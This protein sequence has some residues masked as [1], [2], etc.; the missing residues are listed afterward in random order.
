[1]SDCEQDKREDSATE[2]KQ[3]KALAWR[4]CVYGGM[5]RFSEC[6]WFCEE[7]ERMRIRAGVPESDLSGHALEPTREV[8]RRMASLE[9]EREVLLA[10]VRELEA[11]RDKMKAALE[12]CVGSMTCCYVGREADKLEKDA[13]KEARAV[14]AVIRANAGEAG[15]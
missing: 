4:F 8:V 14:M 10:R 11:E 2:Y 5:R 15:K 12:C 3:R 1:M 6:P 7:L 13:I 9:S